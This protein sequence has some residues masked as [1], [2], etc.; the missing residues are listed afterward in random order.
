MRITFA[1]CHANGNSNVGFIE[2]FLNIFFFCVRT[3]D[4]WH[5]LIDVKVLH[6]HSWC[7][8]EKIVHFFVIFSTLF[9]PIIMKFC[10]IKIQNDRMK[11]K[12]KILPH[13][14][15]RIRFQ[16]PFYFFFFF[17]VYQK[18]N[19]KITPLHMYLHMRHTIYRLCVSISGNV[20]DFWKFWIC[21]NPLQD[22]VKW[23]E[24]SYFSQLWIR[25]FVNWKTRT[26]KQK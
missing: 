20:Y 14:G 19:S 6:G 21:V 26:H 7:I 5:A 10:W 22:E 15:I 24:C 13:F 8:L 9:V 2:E 1:N 25:W 12:E 4:S 17:F 11:K 3:S 16:K 23:C 18:Y